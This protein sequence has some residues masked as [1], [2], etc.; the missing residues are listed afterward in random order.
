MLQSNYDK[1]TS[2]NF[3]LIIWITKKKQSIIYIIKEK[4]LFKIESVRI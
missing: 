3:I 4:I 1:E 2:F